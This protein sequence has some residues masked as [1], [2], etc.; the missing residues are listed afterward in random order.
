MWGEIISSSYRFSSENR[1]PRL[2]DLV[3][4][5]IRTKRY[6]IRTK[7]AYVQWIRRFI[8]FHHKRHPREMGADEVGQFWS[9]LAVNWHVAASTQNQALS[10]IV[11][12]YQEVLKQAI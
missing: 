1:Q 10:A 5:A 11:F 2:L 4:Q 8:V 12:L 7:G 3:R 9:D 6:S